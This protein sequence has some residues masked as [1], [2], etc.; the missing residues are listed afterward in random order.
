LAEQQIVQVSPVHLGRLLADA[1]LS[2][3]RTRTW[4][5]SPDPDYEVKTARVLGLTREQPADGVVEL[6]CEGS[7]ASHQATSP[8]SRANFS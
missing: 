1:N 8:Q 6:T 2:F 3:Q 5:A 4:K 7:F